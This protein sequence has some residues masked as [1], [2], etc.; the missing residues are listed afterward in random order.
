MQLIKWIRRPKNRQIPTQDGNSLIHRHTP[1]NSNDTSFPSGLPA[2]IGNTPLIRIPSLS[3]ATGCEILAKA[4]FLNPGGSVKD[5]VALEIIQEAFLDGRLVAG[6][7]ITEGTVGSTGVSLAMVAA[8]YGCRCFI[9]MPDDAAIEKSQ[10]LQALGAEVERLR[11]VSIAHPSHFVNVA[12]RRAASEPNALF[13]DQFENP[14]N[15]R[16]HLLTGQEIWAQSG[17]KV[18][19]F[20]SGAGTGGTIAGVSAALKQ[21]NSRIKV[22]LVDPPGSGLYNR[23][24]RGVMY[25]S[26]EAEGKRLKHPFDTITEGVGINRLTANFAKAKVDGAFKATDKESVE[27]AQYL[28]RNEGLFVGSSAAVNCV[29]AVKIARKLGPG[30]VIV[31]ILCDGGHRHLS[32]F[33]NKEYLEQHGLTPTCTGKDLDFILLDD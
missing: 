27:M 26:E 24:T 22:Y 1:Q 2:L 32:K 4:E 15:F 13:A 20:V 11:P 21:R 18:D 33:H 31:T 29:G 17:G 5:R 30:H 9:A 28:M 16:A 19:A 10:M 25:T 14:A 8:A 23:V 7:L 12:R 3:E 6:G